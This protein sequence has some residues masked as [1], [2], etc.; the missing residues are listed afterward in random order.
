MYK[1]SFDNNPNYDMP[2]RQSRL[3]FISQK[4]KK[5]NNIYNNTTNLCSLHH[6]KQ[7]ANCTDNVIRPPGREA[8]ASSCI[9]HF[10]VKQ[11]K[12]D[13][14]KTDNRIYKQTRLSEKEM[15]RNDKKEYSINE[16]IKRKEIKINERKK[17]MDCTPMEQKVK[18]LSQCKEVYKKRGVKNTKNVLNDLGKNNLNDIGKKIVDCTP[19][20]QKDKKLS[21]HKEKYKERGVKN[22]N[23]TLNDLGKNN[24]NELGKITKPI[25]NDLGKKILND[26]GEMPIRKPDNHRMLKLPLIQKNKKSQKSKEMYKER[27]VKNTKTILNDLGKH[28]SND[29]GKHYLNDLGTKYSKEIH[30]TTRKTST[31]GK[32]RELQETGK[33]ASE[34]NLNEL[35]K[36]LLLNELGKNLLLNELG[37]NL[38]LN[39]LGKNLLLNELGTN[40]SKETH[41]TWK[42]ASEINSN[43]LE[44]NLLLNELGTKYSNDKTKKKSANSKGNNLQEY[45]KTT[46][47][48]N[49]NELGNNLLLNDLGNLSSTNLD[50]SHVK[51]CAKHQKEAEKKSNLLGNSM[52]C[53]NYTPLNELGKPLNQL[54]E[55]IKSNEKI[56]LDQINKE[57][58]EADKSTSFSNSDDNVSDN[59]MNSSRETQDNDNNNNFKFF[60]PEFLTV[61]YSNIDQSLTGKLNELIGNIEIHRPDIIMLT[62]IEPKHKKD[63][64]KQI[65]D[66]EINIPNYALFTNQIKKRGVAIYIKNEL[67]PRDCTAIINEK[68]EECVFCEFEGVNDE[69]IL[70]GC[71]YKS[72]NSSKE[73]VENMMKTL[74]N[75]NVNKYDVICITGDFNYPKINWNLSE[76]ATGECEEFVECLKDA[77]LIQKVIKPTRNARQNQKANLIDLVLVND[78]SIISDIIHCA[79]LGASDHDCLY[80]QLY[81]QKKRIKRE[82]RKKYDLNKGNYKE[83]RKNMKKTDWA[84]MENKNIEEGWTFLKDKIIDQMNKHIPKSKMT[85]TKKY[86]PVWMNDKILR[87]IKKKYHAFKRYLITKQGKEY[88]KYIRQ[89]NACKKEIKKAKK[90]H[91]ENIAKGCKEDPS[92]FWKYVNDRCKTNVGISSL[93][94]KDGNLKTSDKERADILN[95]FFTSV[96]LKEDMT[97]IPNMGEGSFSKGKIMSDIEITPE[98]V[99]KKLN[100]LKP[101]KAQGPDQIPPRVLKELSKELAVPLSILFKK[102]IEEGKIPEEWKF[103]EVTAIFKKGNKTDPGNYRPVSLTCICCKLLEQFIR[104]GIV[105]HMTENDL[106]ND[107]QHGFRKQRSC[108]TQLL[109]V[110]DE[111]TEMIDEGKNIDIIYLDFKKAFDSIPHERLL[112][113]MKAYGITGKTLEW[114]RDFLIGREQRVR[115]GNDYSENS[116]VTSGIPQGSI[117]GPVLFTLFINDLPENLN[118]HCKIFAD[119]TKIYEESNNHAKIQED[120]YLMQRWTEQWNLYFNVAKCKVM[121]IGK[122]NPKQKYYMK[123][124]NEQ[125]VLDT[126]E[127]EKDL[128]ITFDSNLNFENHISNITK[129]ANQM[130]GI[131]R[132]TFTYIDKNILLKLYKALVRSHLEYGNVIWNPHLKKHSIQIERIQR[133]ATKLAPECKNMNYAQ[134]LQFLKLFSLKGRR[135]RGDLI[136]VYKIF[137][138]IDDIHINKILPIASF[139]KTRN[140]DF[141]LRHRYCKKDI[142]KYTFSFRVVDL[143]NSLPTEIK[144][145]PSLNSFKN[146]LDKNKKLSELFY[147]FDE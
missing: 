5:E 128:G 22:T 58:E 40:Y 77:Y 83:I 48:T 23:T 90:K 94:D 67:N 63:P 16:R 45:R 3:S 57:T 93:R 104:D 59:G 88:E 19:I 139:N 123:I 35:G 135:I 71:M 78:E 7:D 146:R 72:P 50:G 1:D 138:Q 56:S 130:L 62:E 73:N 86:K 117:L 29:L 60:S 24:L 92:K 89:R 46:P 132:R 136:Q 21:Q 144:N 81:L 55:P 38:L 2:R 75:E 145:A 142:R 11:K 97:N 43:E 111:L 64:T 66:S 119:D 37:K 10:V 20:E 85:N 107:G 108:I 53:N 80:F 49:L 18:K 110:Y 118:A 115:V 147:D 101:N 129:K 141:K 79:P 65:K 102:S 13:I 32:G 98:S 126:C 34:N 68:F 114:V 137:Q 15:Y 127:E 33:T 120:L 9:N 44:K 61:M 113:K 95:E 47:E 91:E 54:G 70:I 8:A 51:N 26:L 31:N 122:N 87:K 134:R 36:N 106:Y 116:K 140:Q 42:M 27:G 82:S 28:Y 76:S 105:E 39:E 103:A 96:F 121:H 133:R 84:D 100:A 74:K 17:I 125:Q 143:W 112:M 6:R 25:F 12:E 99:E 69:K 124:E 4:N 14:F 131:I 52:N 41:A 109:E 30:D